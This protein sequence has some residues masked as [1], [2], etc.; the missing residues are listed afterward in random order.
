MF[1]RLH[2]TCPAAFVIRKDEPLCVIRSKSNTS[3]NRDDVKSK[4]ATSRISL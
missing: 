1:H 2:T 3:R 4:P